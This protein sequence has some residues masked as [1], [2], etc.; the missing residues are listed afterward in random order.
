MST[1]IPVSDPEAWDAFVASSEKP[2]IMQSWG[3]GELKS[4]TGWR[5]HRLALEREGKWRAGV[6]VLERAF[7]RTGRC[8]F[9]AAR[10]PVPGSGW[11]PADLAA[12]WQG[13]ENL[14]SRRKAVFLKVDPDVPADADWITPPLREAGFGPAPASGGFA[15]VQP[16]CVFR[17]DIAPPEEALL[18]GMEQ[19]TR[20]NI[21]LAEKRGVRVRTAAGRKD[22]ETFHRILTETGQRDGFLVRPLRYFL[23]IEELL[24]GRGQAQYFLAEVEGKALA[25]ALA[26]KLGPVAWYAYGASSGADRQYMP[27]HLVQWTLIRWA[28]SHGCRLY[29]FR[30]VPCDPSPDNPLQGLYRFKKGFNGRFTRFVG[31][32]DRVY[33]PWFYRAWVYGWPLFKKIRKLV[34]SRLGRAPAVEGME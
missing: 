21:R 29:D 6:S 11:T 30:A 2:H 20:Y 18:K 3:W 31:E 24:S 5:P 12:L 4:R 1:L 15:G 7:P 19:K 10:G 27:N 8:F 25:G 23:D 17:L 26:L 16:R 33:S 28:K 13:V 34:K 32:F 22:L 14:A 9:Y